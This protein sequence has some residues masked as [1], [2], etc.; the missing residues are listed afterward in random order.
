MHGYFIGGL[1]KK[2]H[3]NQ[4][5]LKRV[6][7]TSQRTTKDDWVDW[8]RHFAVELLR[9]SPCAALRSC[10]TLAHYHPIAGDLF[11]AA[12]V[13]CWTELCVRPPLAHAAM[14]VLYPSFYKN[15]VKLIYGFFFGFFSIFFLAFFRFLPAFFFQFFRFFSVFR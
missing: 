6:W 15:K 1:G 3:L 7:D 13:S 12:F 4:A 5:N 8:M 9:E 11:N 2:L 14:P 10:A